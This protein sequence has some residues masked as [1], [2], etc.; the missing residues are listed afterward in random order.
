[1]YV[2][3]YVRVYMFYLFSFPLSSLT[4][5][6]YS[7]YIDRLFIQCY[8][9]CYGNGYYQQNT[10]YQKVSKSVDFR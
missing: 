7:W 8:K 5:L 9:G 4:C 6:C 10:V 2:C 3:M 1:M